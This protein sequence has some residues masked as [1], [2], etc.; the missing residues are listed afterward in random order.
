MHTDGLDNSGILIE[1]RK[2]Q[3]EVAVLCRKVENRVVAQGVTVVCGAKH[4]MR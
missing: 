2:G 3:R 1:E 4:A